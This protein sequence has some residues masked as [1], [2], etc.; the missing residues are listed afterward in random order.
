[1]A[2]LIVPM[3]KG[4]INKANSAKCVSNLR[5][6]GMA[7]QSY[8]NDNNGYLPQHNPVPTAAGGFQCWDAINPYIGCNYGY[9]YDKPESVRR[10]P[11]FC[12]GERE[13]TPP[14][15][16]YAPNRELLKSQG[17]SPI[18]QVAIVSPSKY[19]VMSDSFAANAIYSDSVSKMTNWTQLTRRHGGIPNFLYADWHVAAFTQKIVGL[20][21]SGGD[22]PFYRA[23][24]EARYAQ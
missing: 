22:A 8:A 21:D 19:V 6:L 20:N 15:T 24:W 23:L 2:A 14:F 12:P 9:I 7:F 18:A 17:N 10:T 11:L 3:V 13:I 16:T 4:A 1:M 5:S